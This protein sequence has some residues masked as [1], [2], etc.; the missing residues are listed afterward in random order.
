MAD[1]E[2]RS[3]M[4]QLRSGPIITGGVLVGFGTMLVLAGIAVGSA[5][6]FAATRRWIQ[7]MEV[8][9]SELA[10]QNWARARAAAVAGTAAWQ[11]GTPAARE[12]AG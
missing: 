1:T 2:T 7:A 3:N 11:N 5:H 4:P 9:P 12:A 10:K 8:P 6:V